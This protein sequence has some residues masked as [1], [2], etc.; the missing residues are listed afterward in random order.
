MKW[1]SYANGRTLRGSDFTMEQ[2]LG[3]TLSS[4]A[5]IFSHQSDDKLTEPVVRKG[6]HQF[7]TDATL[8]V[9]PSHLAKQWQQEVKKHAHK[10]K[11]TKVVVITTKPQ[12][13]Q[14]SYKDLIQ[15]DVVVVSVQFF[16]V[17]HAFWS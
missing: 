4:L 17:Q 9:C 14:V 13:Q 11:N 12:H 6:A 7:L 16:Q 1:Y 5:L 2:G 8:V 15:A 3:K 10:P